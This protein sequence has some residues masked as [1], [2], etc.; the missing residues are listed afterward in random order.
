MAILT[1]SGRIAVAHYIAEQPLHM[2][3]GSG[4]A[5]WDTVP[6]PATPNETSLVDEVGRLKATTVQFALPDSDGPIALP[7]GSFAISAQ[8]SK[9][10]LLTFEFDYT[11]AVGEDIRELGVFVGTETQSGIP[12]NSRYLIPSQIASPGRM[13]VAER[14]GKFTR[15][16]NTKQKFTYVIQF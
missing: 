1:E 5:A 8:P 13:L 3:W 12:A 14:V 2:A 11:D 16:A 4:A 6:V 10:L 7:E 15:A 9:Y